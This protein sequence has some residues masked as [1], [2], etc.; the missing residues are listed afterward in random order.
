LIE[1]GDV[2]VP[3]TV[4]VNERLS[5]DERVA[6]AAKV[7]QRAEAAQIVELEDAALGIEHTRALGIPGGIG[8]LRE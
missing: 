8:A 6:L 2:D 1:Q 4:I 5:I 7:R 3:V